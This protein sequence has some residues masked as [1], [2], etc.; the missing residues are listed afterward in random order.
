LPFTFVSL[1]SPMTRKH[2][3]IVAAARRLVADGGF[4]AAQ[5]AAIADAAGVSTGTV[6]RYFPSKAYLLS[7]VYRHVAQRE[8][9]VVAAIAL[10][11]GTARTRLAN[12]IRAFAERAVKGRK[13]AFAML[14]EPVEPEVLAERSRYHV[15]F[16]RIFETI[17]AD[18]IRAGEFPEQDLP[19][20]AACTVGALS[21]ALAMP[22][23]D[24]ALVS[25][26]GAARTIDGI[27]A[28][29][30]GALAA[31]DGA[32]RRDLVAER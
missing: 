29:C 1:E 9:E 18:G 30:L 32:A 21:F 3:D 15:L 13:T 10:A 4:H 27:V 8:V 6:Y 2:T 31:P 5:V 24:E 23:G 28:Y 12:A 26:V 11:G 20:S 7:E 16:A 17:V 19:T 25:G 14:V 22:L